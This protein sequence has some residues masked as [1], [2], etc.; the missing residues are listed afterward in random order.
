VFGEHR[1]EGHLAPAKVW[2]QV[3]EPVGAP[4]DARYPDTD[5]DEMRSGWGKSHELPGEATDSF[6]GRC[7]GK[8]SAPV[9]GLEYSLVDMASQP[10]TS[11]DEGLGSKL[12]GKHPGPF[13]IQ[14]DE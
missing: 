5:T 13:G 6:D 9:S 12:Y 8:L 4:H 1:S 10:D 7:R 2:R 14:A 11:Y 3:D